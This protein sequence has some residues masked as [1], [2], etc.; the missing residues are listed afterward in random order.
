M[1]LV[2]SRLGLFTAA[3]SGFGREVLH[4][5]GAP[6]LPKLRGNFAEFLNEGFLDHLGILYPPTCVGFGTG[7]WN[8]PRGFSR[9]H[10][11][12]DFRHYVTASCL[13]LEAGFRPAGL[14]SCPSTTNGWD[15]L[16]YPV[17]PSVITVPTWYGNINPLSIA[18]AFRPRL[19]SRLTLRRLAL[20]RNPWAF[21]GGV[22]SPLFRY[23]C[24]HSHSRCLH[25]WVT[26]PLRSAPGRSPTT[27]ARPE[28]AA[29]VPDL[30]P[31]TLSARE[32]LTSELL[33]TLSRVA[34]SKPTSWLS[35]HPH[36]VYHLVRI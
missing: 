19:R 35:V 9:G 14:R 8:L 33:R 32:H 7:T 6:L 30:S 2:N 15:P 22:S 36:I 11:F 29:S 13:S 17:L 26:P 18:Y 21:G 20:L 16:S 24:Q 12:R 4:P 23:S 5:N 27:P 10:G 34:A 28:S 31:A 25:G 3:P 1:F